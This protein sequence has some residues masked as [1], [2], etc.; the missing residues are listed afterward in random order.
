MSSIYIPWRQVLIFSFFLFIHLA[1]YAAETH[2]LSKVT[3]SIVGC[4]LSLCLVLDFI[5]KG[6][7]LSLLIPTVS[8]EDTS[9]PGQQVWKALR[10]VFVAVQ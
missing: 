6:F 7:G 9:G 1:Q 5:S 2:G 10:D 8:T 3:G 4:R